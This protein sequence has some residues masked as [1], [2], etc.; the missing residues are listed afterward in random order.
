MRNAETELGVPS[1][2]INP[3]SER[4]GP[5]AQM[6][7]SWQEIYQISGDNLLVYCL[8]LLRHGVLRIFGNLQRVSSQATGPRRKP[9]DHG[10]GMITLYVANYFLGS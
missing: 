6:I 4:R 10:V 9:G 3:G 8:F 7:Q 2:L 5:R 1:E